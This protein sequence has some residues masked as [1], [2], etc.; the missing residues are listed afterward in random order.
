VTLEMGARLIHAQFH[1]VSG[2]SNLYR[3]QWQGGRVTTGGT[4]K[5]V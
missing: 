3:G 1:A 5:Q 2:A 4:E